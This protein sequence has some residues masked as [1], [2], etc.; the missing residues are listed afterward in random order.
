VEENASKKTCDL[1]LAEKVG[2][3]QNWFSSI[4]PSGSA[5]QPSMKG[6]PDFCGLFPF[7]S[8]ADNCRNWQQHSKT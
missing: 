8:C 4:T 5:Y 3:I 2:K 1:Y 7:I 6:L